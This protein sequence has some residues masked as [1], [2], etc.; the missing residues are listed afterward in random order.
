MPCGGIYPLWHP[1]GSVAHFAAPMLGS[2]AADACFYCGKLE[3]PC[4]HFCDEWDCYLHAGCSDAFL[5]TEEGKI[6]LAHG[7]EVIR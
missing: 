4:T 3:P 7:H 5:D 6:V 2:S 1:D